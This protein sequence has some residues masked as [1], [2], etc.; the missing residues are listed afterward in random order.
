M[1]DWDSLGYE[2]WGHH[3]TL[4]LP[5][6]ISQDCISFINLETSGGIHNLFLPTVAGKLTGNL[7]HL[8]DQMNVGDRAALQPHASQTNHTGKVFSR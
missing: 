7:T 2:Q 3:S 8:S 1:Q 5:C 6:F 4:P